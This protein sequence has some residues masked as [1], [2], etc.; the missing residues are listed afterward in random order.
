METVA[1]SWRHYLFVQELDGIVFVKGVDE[2]MKDGDEDMEGGDEGCTISEHLV[3]TED[4]RVKWCSDWITATWLHK[5]Q[6]EEEKEREMNKGYDHP[7]DV[8]PPWFSCFC[9]V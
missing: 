8:S 3:R 6:E 5:I 7:E 9:C 2:Y 1:R 4:A